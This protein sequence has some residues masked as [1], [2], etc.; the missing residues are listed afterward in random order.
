MQPTTLKLPL[1]LMFSRRESRHDCIGKP[2][3]CLNI[4][5]GPDDRSVRA[6]GT[7]KTATITNDKPNCFLAPIRDAQEVRLCGDAT[8][9]K[10]STLLIRDFGCQ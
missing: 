1:H 8:Q 9:D 4:L 6:F 7:G 2:L 10:A 5:I 3:F